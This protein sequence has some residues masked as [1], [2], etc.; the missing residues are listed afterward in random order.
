MNYYGK[1]K[2]RYKLSVFKC[3]ACQAGTYSFIITLLNSSLQPAAY[4]AQVH[5]LWAASYGQP[6]MD[7][8][9]GHQAKGLLCG[10]MFLDQETALCAGLKSQLKTSPFHMESIH[11]MQLHLLL[12]R[13]HCLNTNFSAVFV[14]ENNSMIYSK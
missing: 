6:A 7:R 12:T 14:R 1:I 11:I 3:G 10:A 13:C 5:D 4:T 9:S 2:T 8:A